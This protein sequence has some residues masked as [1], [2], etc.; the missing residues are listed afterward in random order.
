MHNALLDSEAE[1]SEDD[2]PFDNEL[3]DNDND[4]DNANANANNKDGREGKM[5]IPE[6]I[7]IVERQMT[8]KEKMETM[9]FHR[10]LRE[11]EDEEQIEF[12]KRGVQEGA[13]Y[14]RREYYY[15]ILYCY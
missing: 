15:E 13:N 3:D 14:M 8:E 12:V 6:G 1:E 7:D 9:D 2:L 5:V 10:Q 11:Q 4:N